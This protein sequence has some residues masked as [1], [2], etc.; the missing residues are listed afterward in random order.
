MNK[1]RQRSLRVRVEHEPN[2]FSE[3]C[4]ERIY[5]QLHPTKSR[6]V[7]PNKNNKQGEVEPQKGK[8][9]QQ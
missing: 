7:M 6:A 4:L 1:P 5:E 3:D 9:G 2:R 8:G